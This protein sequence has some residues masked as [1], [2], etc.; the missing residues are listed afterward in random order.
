MYDSMRDYLVFLEKPTT[1]SKMLVMC[2]DPKY[3]K[4]FVKDVVTWKRE[5]D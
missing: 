4:E 5:E 2:N 1:G 3:I